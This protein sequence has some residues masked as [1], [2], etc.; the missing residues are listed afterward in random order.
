[1]VLQ[2]LSVRNVPVGVLPVGGSHRSFLVREPGT[3]GID[4]SKILNYRF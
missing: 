2:R 3:S 4:H 1:M